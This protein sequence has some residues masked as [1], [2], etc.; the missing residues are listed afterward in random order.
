[1]I[2]TENI[3]PFVRAVNNY[4]CIK[5]LARLQNGEN[6]NF[7]IGL[8]ATSTFFMLFKSWARHV[9]SLD[10]SRLYF[11]PVGMGVFVNA[12]LPHAESY[13]KSHPD[14]S[15]V[16]EQVTG[17]LCKVVALSGNVC[18]HVLQQTD[19]VLIV[20]N[21]VSSVALIKLGFRAHGAI[22]LLGLGLTALDRL[23]KLPKI[24]DDYIEPIAFVANIYETLTLPIP[25]F[26]RLINLIPSVTRIARQLFPR[27]QLNSLLPQFLDKPL[28]LRHIV[29]HP[30]GMPNL[31][32][33]LLTLDSNYVYSKLKLERPQPATLQWAVH[34]RLAQWRGSVLHQEIE[35]RSDLDSLGGHQNENLINYIRSGLWHRLQIGNPS[36]TYAQRF[37]LH[38]IIPRLPEETVLEYIYFSLCYNYKVC[39]DPKYAFSPNLLQELLEQVS[40]RIDSADEVFKVTYEATKPTTNQPLNVTR[41]TFH[42]ESELIENWMKDI[43]ERRGITFIDPEDPQRPTEWI[44]IDPN[45]NRSLSAVGVELLLWDMGIFKVLT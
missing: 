29:P 45:G 13:L 44:N 12:V 9:P 14:L 32:M 41:P 33:T 40:A 16:T 20:A 36:L 26:L 28:H 31:N 42:I 27:L 37:L 34:H 17:A 43:S 6:Q 5:T 38:F 4:S 1:M 7:I 23:N 10:R 25:L 8:L 18:R 3:R 11:I 39:V 19:K 24:V 30:T 2:I 15:S 22:G 35:K 21:F